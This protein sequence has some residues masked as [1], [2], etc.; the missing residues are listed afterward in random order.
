MLGKCFPSTFFFAK[1]RV[2]Y[3]SLF[4]TRETS[5]EWAKS[6]STNVLP[7]VRE[8]LQFAGLAAKKQ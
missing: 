2:D 5:L 6:A 3:Y 1:E 4:S 7:Q 8:V